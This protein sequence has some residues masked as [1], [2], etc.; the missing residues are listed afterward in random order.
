MKV[1]AFLMPNHPPE[2]DFAEGHY[3]NLDTLEYYD[4]IGFE[5]AWI[6]CHYTVPREPNPAP[7]LLVAQA[8]LRTKNLRVSPGG[9]ILG[10]ETALLEAL[11]DKRG[12]PRNKPP[13]PGPPLL[14][15][16]RF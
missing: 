9:Y 5:E 11:E 12:E 3:H 4:S 10:E 6:G 13:Y 14:L 16:T 7:D 2:R 15:A 8:L 1:G